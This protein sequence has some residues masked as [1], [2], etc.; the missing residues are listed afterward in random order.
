[1]NSS[2]LVDEMSSTI[3][4]AKST[5]SSPQTIPNSSKLTSYHR[6]SGNTNCLMRE[7]CEGNGRASLYKIVLGI[8]LGRGVLFIYFLKFCFLC[9]FSVGGP[10]LVWNKIGWIGQFYGW[11]DHRTSS[12]IVLSE[13]GENRLI[14][15]LVQLISK[16]SPD[17]FNCICCP[18]S[19][20]CRRG[21]GG[22]GHQWVGLGHKWTITDAMLG[23]DKESMF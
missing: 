7:S 14:P 21:L 5:G 9:F 10:R 6:S 12:R 3:V 4:D 1:M 13:I 2:T 23:F 17:T 19:F 18:G 20:G 11:A 15:V 8:F 22:W 16:T